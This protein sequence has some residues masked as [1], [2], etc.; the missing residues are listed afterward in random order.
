MRVGRKSAAASLTLL[1]LYAVMLV[2]VGVL[3][4]GLWLPQRLPALVGGSSVGDGMVTVS[5]EVFDGSK[6]MSAN[7]VLG[8]SQVLRSPVSGVLTKTKCEEGGTVT[9]GTA[10]LAVNG[11]PV[12]A[13]ASGVPLWR[14]ITYGMKGADVTAVQKELKRL[15]FKVYVTGVWDGASRT[16]MKALLEKVGLSSTTGAL[17]VS[18]V[19]WMPSAALVVS[20]CGFQVGDPIGTGAVWAKSGAGL[21]GLTLA[22]PPGNGW[23]AVYHDATAPVGNDGEITDEAF[24]ALVGASVDFAFATAPG[25][26]GTVQLTVRLAQALNV[27]VVPPGAIIPTGPGAGCVVG[28]DGSVVLVSIVASSLGKTM[29][30]VTGGVSPSLVQVAPDSGTVCS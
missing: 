3:V 5:V 27:L 21:V 13:L 14:D 8:Q 1:G 12:L 25:G 4:A 17:L 9:S 22:N 23:I 26:P 20:A 11:S 2:A 16:A 30:T 15:G 6:T 29:V 19:I 28:G 18:Q 24:L 7:V 10:P